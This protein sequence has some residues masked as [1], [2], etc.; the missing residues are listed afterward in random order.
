MSFPVNEQ[1]PNKHRTSTEQD[2]VID[3]QSEKNET[4]ENNR[5]TIEQ[6]PEQVKSLISIM[7]KGEYS[8]S[9]LMAQLQLKH[10]PTFIYNYMQPALKAG[11]IE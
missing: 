5:T 9:D 6:V 2:N 10:R 3:N 1:A 4:Y 7:G 11:L 8:T